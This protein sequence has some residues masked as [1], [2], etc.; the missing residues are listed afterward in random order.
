M[1]RELLGLLAAIVV[2]ILGYFGIKEIGSKTPAFVFPKETNDTYDLSPVV[3]KGESEDMFDEDGADEI[4]GSAEGGKYDGVVFLREKTDLDSV[5]IN[6]F[7]VVKKCKIKGDLICHGN[8]ALKDC[9]VGGKIVANGQIYL[10]RSKC[11]SLAI[12]G[13]ANLTESVVPN[14]VL[15]GKLRGL[16]LTCDQLELKPVGKDCNTGHAE[17]PFIRL[18]DSK[19]KEI[20]LP[21]DM[22]RK[23]AVE[24]Q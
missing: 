24:E 12:H 5:E 1:F 11:K 4:T 6:G 22:D 10:V 16:K 23:T 7:G 13:S 17:P 15:C 9:E 3:G 8:V 14:V 18:T 2:I 20:K 21:K 19:V